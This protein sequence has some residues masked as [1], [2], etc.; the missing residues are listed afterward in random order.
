MIFIL[1]VLLLTMP[2]ENR[3]L[4]VVY[5]LWAALTGTTMFTMGGSYWGKFYIAAVLLFAAALLLPLHLEIAPV[6]VGTIMS[7]NQLAQGL[8]LRRARREAGEE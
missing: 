4:L 2:A 8:A 7:A 5:P 6:V 1:M 3:N